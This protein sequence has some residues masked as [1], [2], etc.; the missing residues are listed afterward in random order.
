ME[1]LVLKKDGKLIKTEWVYDN[2][3]EEGSYVDS[4]VTDKGFFHLQDEC[5]LDSDV[6]L[7][8]IFL[9]LNS[10]LDLY[11][12]V[13]RIWTKE[14]VKEG[15][16]GSPIK[17][18]EI[19]Y[20]ELYYHLEYNRIEENQP[21]RLD[22]LKHPD[23]HGV[24]KILEEDHDFCKK[25]ERIPYSLS[26]Q[27]TL[28]LID[29]PVKLRHEVEVY[30]DDYTQKTYKPPTPL[31]KF[32]HVPYTLFNILYGIMWELSFFGAPEARDEKGQEI[33]GIVAN[34]KEENLVPFPI[35]KT[36]DKDDKV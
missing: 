24:G 17:E 23:F 33:L 11:D 21:F 2:E 12:S 8:D 3:K 16:S 31:I 20:L 35:E 29:L 19:E 30:E 14:L 26:F 7:K 5:T 15:L 13:L 27:S 4:D 9:L 32:S 6:T 10:E 22:G 18:T 34:I 28:N 1:K 25:G 36:L